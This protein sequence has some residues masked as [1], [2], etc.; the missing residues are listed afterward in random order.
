LKKPLD[1]RNNILF[2]DKGY[3]EGIAKKQGNVAG[4]EIK[5]RNTKLMD[6]YL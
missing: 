4:E 2:T 1:K 3:S 5:Q 6:S